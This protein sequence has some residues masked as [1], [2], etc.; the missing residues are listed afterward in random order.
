MFVDAPKSAD[1][2]VPLAKMIRENLLFLLGLSPILIAM[3]RVFLT[4]QGDYGTIM[5]LVR[6]LDVRTLI[7]ATFV[8]SV[9]IFT[10]GRPAEPDMPEPYAVRIRPSRH[11]YGSKR[12]FDSEPRPRALPNQ[13]T[14]DARSPQRPLESWRFR[15]FRLALVGAVDIAAEAELG[16]AG[17]M[18]G[19]L[20][21]QPAGSPR[22]VRCIRSGPGC[23]CC[24]R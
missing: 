8:R 5:T 6:T 17:Q 24:V 20:A 21:C 18:A 13:P 11:Q 2:E 16:V 19:W 23:C 1:Q 15:T 3:M 9:G 12:L 4:A 10:A 14:A 22:C 7:I